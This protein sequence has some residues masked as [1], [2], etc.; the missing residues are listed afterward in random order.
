M[1]SSSQRV[2]GEHELVY[3]QESKGYSGDMSTRFSV[4]VPYLLALTMLNLNGLTH[5]P[6]LRMT[7]A[8]VTQFAC[9]IVP[10]RVRVRHCVDQ[11]PTW[12]VDVTLIIGPYPS[13][14]M[15]LVNFHAPRADHF[16]SISDDHHCHAPQRSNTDLTQLPQVLSN[17]RTAQDLY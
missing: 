2:R 13:I 8:T 11:V 4:C 6:C 17:G 3:I 12:P 10:H 15:Q 14:D 9:P 16:M 7:A 5:D 1:A